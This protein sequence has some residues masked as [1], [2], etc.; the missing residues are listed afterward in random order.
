MKLRKSTMLGV[1]ITAVTALAAFAVIVIS[2]PDRVFR[3][4]ASM[5]AVGQGS[6]S[7][8]GH[9]EYDYAFLNGSNL[10]S[11]ALGADP[12]SNQVFA[13][14]IDCDSGVAS[15]LVFDK[16]DSNITIIATSSSIDKVRQQG[17]KANF[18]NSERFVAR[19]DVNPVGNLA[20]GFLTVAGRLDLDSNGC[21]QAVL[22]KLDR[23]SNDVQLG[24]QDVANT[25]QDS[26]SKDP[27]LRTRRAGRA[28]F[29]GVL[30]V[31][32]GGGTNTVLIPFGHMTF[33]RQLD[34]FI[35]E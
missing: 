33:R 20:G 14:E 28:H 1:A 25:E 8:S 29:I 16:S 7:V 12:T 24:D 17:L 5:V 15:L 18:V 10:V 23:D 19:F 4:T 27:D 3:T 35:V 6:N 31:V 32:G 30:D 13:M 9:L 22:I 21:P 11:L 34:E 2:N 26:K